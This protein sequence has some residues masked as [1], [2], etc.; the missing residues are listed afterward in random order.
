M[1]ILVI[2]DLHIPYRAV[3]LPQ[4]FKKLLVPGKIQQILCT[5]NVTDQETNEYL[6]TIAADF[7]AVKGDFDE[8]MSLPTSKIITHGQLRI[9]FTHGHLII[10]QCDP[11]ALAIA[12]RQMDVD[13]FI[14]GGLHK[15]E[16]YELDGRFFVSPGT[17]TGAMSILDPEEATPSFVLMDIQGAVLVLYV[18]QLIDGDVKVEKVQFRKNM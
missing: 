2:G 12:A 9:G 13:V 17:A 4:K 5:G 16:A 8:N 10:P 3:D 7:Q 1:L 18:Y 6:R 14:Y 11:D 15:F